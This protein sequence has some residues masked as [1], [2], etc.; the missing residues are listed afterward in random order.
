MKCFVSPPTHQTHQVTHY[1][2]N[3]AEMYESGVGIDVEK[4]PD[5]ASY[6]AATATIQ[7]TGEDESMTP[8][9][10]SVGWTNIDWG[11]NNIT[12][13]PTVARPLDAAVPLGNAA[14]Y[15]GFVVAER[16]RADNVEFATQAINAQSAGAEGLIIVN[17]ANDA[18]PLA[19]HAHPQSV[20]VTIPVFLVEREAGLR[21]IREIRSLGQVIITYERTAITPS[22]HPNINE[23]LANP[24][25]NPIPDWHVSLDLLQRRQPEVTRKFNVSFYH[26]SIA[27]QYA[28]G[29]GI[30]VDKHPDI[31]AFF[32]DAIPSTHPSIMEMLAN[33]AD[34]PI[35]DWHP[36][37][38][39]LQQRAPERSRVVPVPTAHPNASFLYTS[40]FGVPATHPDVQAYLDGFLP[41]THPS[42]LM[43]MLK[44]PKSFPLPDFHPQLDAF[45]LRD[46][47][48]VA[49]AQAARDVDLS[50][51]VWYESIF[52]YV[53]PK[54]SIG[55]HHPL[56]DEMYGEGSPQP[57]GHASVQA[58][59]EEFLPPAHPDVDAMLSDPSGNPLPPWH[60]ALSSL[61]VRRSMWSPGLLLCLLVLGWF[62][63]LAGFR[64]FGCCCGDGNDMQNGAAVE[65]AAAA[66]AKAWADTLQGL[67]GV[68]NG[69]SSR[70]GDGSESA[71]LGAA[72]DAKMVS[73]PLLGS[74]ATPTALDVGSRVN[75][76][77]YGCPGVLRFF[78]AHVTDNKLRCGVALEQAVGKHSGTVK[79]HA[80]FECAHKCGVLVKPTKVTL[81]EDALYDADRTINIDSPA[82]AEARAAVVQGGGSAHVAASDG[83]AHDDEMAFGFGV[84]E[85]EHAAQGDGDGGDD[86]GIAAGFG[87]AVEAED[88]VPTD[89]TDDNDAN[90][91]NQEASAAS[92][93]SLR[94]RKRDPEAVERRILEEEGAAQ[95][96]GGGLFLDR[97]T[98]SSKPNSNG[99]GTANESVPEI[100]FLKEDHAALALPAN[101]ATG[102]CWQQITE[103]R[104]PLW[105]LAS[106]WASGNVVFL[107]WYVAL[108]ATAL[109]V[110]KTHTVG[111]GLGSLAAANTFFL[112]VP[113]T[114][115]SVLTWFLGLP[116][117]YLILYHR[118]L[119]RF[120]MVCAFL[121]FL[122][123][124]KKFATQTGE[125]FTEKVYWTGFAAAM[126]GVV[127]VLTTFDWVRRKHFNVFY[128]SHFSFLGFFI[129]TY[130][131]ARAARPF[132]LAGIAVY[133][134]DKLLSALW[135]LI[136]CR[137][138]VFREVGDN[139]VQVQFPKHWWSKTVGTYK[140]GQYMF[141]N[142]P[143][144]SIH[145]W[146]PF[147]ITSGPR[148]DYV[149]LHIKGLGDH[150]RKIVE[151]AKDCANGGGGSGGS[152]SG[153][154]S[155]GKPVWIRRDGPYG[156][157]DF[158]YR[159]FGAL[160]LAGGGVG[161]TPIIGI[162][163]DIYDAD[164]GGQA[165]GAA[166][167][168]RPHRMECVYVVWTMRRPEEAAPFAKVLRE[169]AS[170]A[171]RRHDLPE[172]R[173]AL[174]VTRAKAALAPPFI[175]GRPKVDAM[176]QEVC[177]RHCQE[178]TLVFAC[179]PK[180]MV[181]S[182]WDASTQRNT[183][184]QRVHF[185]AET[186]EL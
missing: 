105:K 100:T 47:D 83:D 136:P 88:G 80:Y 1:H 67:E 110:A 166:A 102:Y 60:P 27:E 125:R 7:W 21:L 4:H 31:G 170:V 152:G 65:A 134:L 115:N 3:L 151:Y 137:T 97:H 14:F 146:H 2:P 23:M 84:V 58:L 79:G 64:V 66:E 10:P 141:V 68:A 163:K 174:H 38:D 6:F 128:W 111:L 147:S 28:Q 142:F 181:N 93:S 127:I 104:W 95:K 122:F 52:G 75:V 178:P 5:I 148:D 81:A 96:V 54:M 57:R 92:A 73:F 37:L 70:S 144:L 78:G 172:L 117:D 87:D 43:A 173:L 139:V 39:D 135:S 124:A 34:N 158:D 182:L 101:N 55:F 13:A 11:T 15:G 180:L 150:T 24:K 99:N 62:G 44:D 33:P 132:L 63:L 175:A 74:G 177:E 161:I 98:G 29:I 59:L 90:E 56:L 36:V 168:A 112:I 162:L 25:E 120:T 154:G 72:G 138:L 123:F 149:E 46:D 35:P 91:G 50:A 157:P 164:E 89:G 133:G 30:D 77:G 22:T 42:D 153:G 12:L 45:L 108:N 107:V 19:L 106:Q 76:E 160:V 179:G 9:L 129:F 126:C 155:G 116:F 16:N 109:V 40:G 103:R 41:A 156:A 118:F 48:V 94:R 183:A 114:R 20:H 82:L 171:A 71:G 32:A 61:V 184:E 185:H 131:H 53:V 8:S 17:D 169:Y 26:P 159:R 145:E 121:H 113:A 167:H 85:D 69:A 18:L 86:D 49:A 130:L 176:L 186:F 165:A 140:V 119:G 51:Y 143:G